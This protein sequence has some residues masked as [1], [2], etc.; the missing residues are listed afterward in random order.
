[1]T[2]RLPEGQNQFEKDL[3]A[4][5]KVIAR[6]FYESIERLQ[7]GNW[8]KIKLLKSA[9]CFFLLLCALHFEFRAGLAENKSR[10]SLKRKWIGEISL[11]TKD[12]FIECLRNRRWRITCRQYGITSSLSVSSPACASRIDSLQTFPRANRLLSG[13]FASSP[14]FLIS[15][16]T[17]MQFAHAND[18]GNRF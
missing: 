15:K 14:Q 6:N 18:S 11:G 2:S 10:R 12:A 17:F 1:M 13:I 16:T 5:V 3:C 8:I 7:N 4:K 9:S